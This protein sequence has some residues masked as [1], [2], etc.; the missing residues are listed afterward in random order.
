MI[1]ESELRIGNYVNGHKTVWTI[2]H[3]DF[4]MADPD[5]GELPYDPIPLTEECFLK[6]EHETDENG[7]KFIWHNKEA[8]TRY[9][10]LD[11]IRGL[12]FIGLFK[13]YHN[14]IMKWPH[15]DS[16]HLFQTLH[17]ALTGEELTIKN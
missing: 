15:I 5:T 2:D 4:N 1:K 10:L 3:T 7:D 12:K 17:F 9:Y 14:P 6:F 8:D 16:I 11:G 13:S